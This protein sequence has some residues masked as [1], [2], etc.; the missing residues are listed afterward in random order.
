MTKSLSL[1]AFTLFLFIG[2]SL[3]AYSQTRSNRGRGSSI[4]NGSRH[5]AAP[6]ARSRSRVR[7]TSPQRSRSTVRR[8]RPSRNRSNIGRTRPTRSRSDYS[9]GRTTRPNRSIHHRTPRR[10]S[11][12]SHRAHPARR[13]VRRYN[14]YSHSPYRHNYVARRRYLRT[15]NYARH[16]RSLNSSYFYRNWIFYPSARVNGYYVYNNYPYFV[17]N[18]YQH[19]YSNVDYCDYQLVDSYSDY[20]VREYNNRICSFGYDECARDRDYEN[21]HEYSERYFCAERYSTYY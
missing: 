9:R 5:R 4:G 2:A 6:P 10:S 8:S 14:P 1:C 3:D 20:V 13:H 17:Y 19:R 11:R 16:L 12:I 18:G 15:V 7:R 21:R